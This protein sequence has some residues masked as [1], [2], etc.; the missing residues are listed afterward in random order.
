MS[1]VSNGL[2]RGNLATLNNGSENS[3]SHG[4]PRGNRFLLSALSAQR[5][6]RDRSVSY[7]TSETIWAD[8]FFD[9]LH[10][11]IT[12]RSPAVISL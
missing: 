9:S 2:S 5:D 3:F 6:P 8:N 11:T 12:Y 1:F 10:Q 7:R 4:T